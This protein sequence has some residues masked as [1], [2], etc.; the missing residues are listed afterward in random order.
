M[1]DNKTTYNEYVFC[2]NCSFRGKIE[3][4]KG[5]SVNLEICPNCGNLTILRDP[6]GELLDRPHRPTSYR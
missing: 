3:I 4:N 5:S 6:N 1:T 2:K